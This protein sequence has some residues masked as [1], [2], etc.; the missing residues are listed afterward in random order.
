MNL[1]LI[2][3]IFLFYLFSLALGDAWGVVKLNNKNETYE[4]WKYIKIFEDKNGTL[5]LDDFLNKRSELVFEGERKKVPNF[6]INSSTFWVELRL[7]NESKINDWFLVL[8]YH[9]LDHVEFYKKVE[10][11]WK[12]FLTGDRKKFEEREIEHRGFVFKI[13]P[14][15][16]STYIFKLKSKGSMQIP[17]TIYS[18]TEFYKSEAS[19]NYGFG[20]FSGFFIVMI[21]Y[22]LFVYFSTKNISFIHY[23]FFLT[24]ILLLLMGMNGFGYQY[25]YPFSPFLQ[26]RGIPLM[27]LFVLLAWGLFSKSYLNFEDGMPRLSL[28]LKCFLYGALGFLIISPILSYTFLLKYSLILFLVEASIIVPG[29]F[30]K[31]RERYRPSYFYLVAFCVFILGSVFK[32]LNNLGAVPSTFI[33]T[34]GLYIGASIQ[35]VL[36]ALGLADIINSSIVFFRICSSL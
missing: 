23:V 4:A 5:K 17:L 19:T 29:V 32:V 31:V 11:E 7:R 26:N 22:N 24:S 1:Y 34:Q 10:S 14:T 33:F 13:K 21:L 12:I 8:D 15:L 9:Y 36:L 25:I 3:K 16:D 6:G 2:K 27:G 28:A 20:I 18:P 35:V 30:F